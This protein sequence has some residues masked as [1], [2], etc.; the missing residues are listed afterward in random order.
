MKVSRGDERL[1]PCPPQELCDVTRRGN[2]S[3]RGVPISAIGELGTSVPSD[4]SVGGGR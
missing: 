1:S 2:L 4:E 3:C